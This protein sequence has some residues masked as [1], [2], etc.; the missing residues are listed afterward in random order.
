M[1]RKLL[2][3]PLVG[4]L[5][6][7]L[8]CNGQPP[9]PPPI[10]PGDYASIIGYLKQYIPQQMAEHQV[11]GLSIAL[12]DGQQLIWARGFGFADQARGLQVTDR[13]SVV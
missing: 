4:L 5:L 8:G 12:V 7:N 9:A 1:S 11:P 2:G 3:L 13:K 10:A 6:S